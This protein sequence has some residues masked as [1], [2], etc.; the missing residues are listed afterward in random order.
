MMLERLIADGRI[1][2]AHDRGG[3]R[4][5]EGGGRGD[6]GRRGRAGRARGRRARDRPGAARGARPAALPHQ[7]YGQNV[8]DH[9]VECSQ[10][11]RA[12][13]RRARRLGRDRP[14]GDAAARHRQGRQPR[15]RGLRTPQVGASM[16]RRKGESE[17]VAHAIEAHHNEVEPKTVEAVIVQIADAVSGARPGARGEAL[18]HYVDAAPRPRG[19]RRPP[20]RR[21]EGLRDAGRPRGPGRSSTPATV[22]DEEAAVIARRDRDRRSRRSCD[23]PGRIKITVDPREPVDRLRRVARAGTVRVAQSAACVSVDRIAPHG[24]KP[25]LHRRR[26]PDR[27]RADPLAS[28]GC[29]ATSSRSRARRLIGIGAVSSSCSSPTDRRRRGRT[30]REDEQ[31]QRRSRTPTPRPTSSR[32]RARPATARAGERGAGRTRRAG[33]RRAGR[34]ARPAAARRATARS[35]AA[36]SLHLDRAAAAATRSPTLGTDARARSARTSTPPSPARTPSSSRRRS[37][38]PSADVAKGFPDG[39]MPANYGDQL[40]A[41]SSSSALVALP[42][43]SDEPAAEPG[44]GGSSAAAP[45]ARRYPDHGA[46]MRKRFHVTTFGCQMNEHDSERMK[47][48]LDVARLRRGAEPRRTPT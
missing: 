3:L 40:D 12:D 5:G 34:A 19:D 13:R 8:L 46:A 38:I 6:D 11:R 4:E 47:G 18:E 45:G 25:L 30:P 33:K 26:R 35:T 36:S 2:P 17:A 14:A 29:G 7:S 41:R 16:A 21:R 1:Q 37:S 15:G 27:G 22:D 24:R 31:E 28:S 39:T 23:Y 9:L 48:M 10:D 42:R 20:S 44:V 32:A 43:R